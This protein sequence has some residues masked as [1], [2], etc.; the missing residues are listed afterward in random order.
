MKTV[1]VLASGRSGT[2][3]LSGLFKNNIK[4]CVGKHEPR[5]DMF[6]KPIYWYC[7]GETN[8]I[9]N[10]FLKKKNRIDNYNTN[11]YIETNHAFL[12]SF[13]DVTMQHYPDM[14]VIHLIRN[15]VKVARSELNR[16]MWCDSF[17][18]KLLLARYRPYYKDNDGQKY[19]R[20]ALTWKENI[21]KYEKMKNITPYQKYVVQWIEIENRAMKFL[22]KYKKHKD[23]YT[24]NVPKDLN[25]T[26]ILNDMFNF[27]DLK[28]KN[29]K[30]LLEGNKNENKQKTVITDD[31]KKQFY[32]VIH[33]VP[34]RYLAIFKKEP[35]CNFDWIDVLRSE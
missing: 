7:K 5:P 11:I 15:P 32:E 24:L 30:I 20:W 21:F 26:E 34:K 4:N 33:N 18:M 22:D 27:L 1:F 16:Q 35:Y 23:C 31:E 13:S 14:K 17:H 8:K 10:V 29:D 12:K 2:K 28:L 3:F 25:N 6:G 19:F 9:N